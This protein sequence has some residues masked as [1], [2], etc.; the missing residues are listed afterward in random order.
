M[1]DVSPL[2]LFIAVQLGMAGVGW[3]VAGV[4]LRLSRRAALH[5]AAFNLLGL[6]AAAP[7]MLNPGP[8]EAL[9][10]GL[11][12]L[13]MTG[14]F[15]AMTRGIG[16]FLGRTGAAWPDIAAMAV[17]VLVTAWDV[18]F[19]SQPMLR[20]MLMSALLAAVLLRGALVHARP[21]RAEFGA[22]VAA[23]ITG[24]LLAVGAVFAWHVA[25]AA[26]ALVPEA[27]L[28]MSAPTKENVAVLLLLTSL[29]MLFNLTLCGMAVARLIR[30]LHHL[31]RH[32]GLTKLMNRRALMATLEAEQGRVR[33]GGPP[34]AL[35][36]V[37]VDHFKRVNDM[38]GHAVGDEVLCR[39]AAVLRRSAREVDTVAR[40]GGEEF[41]VLAPLT[42][43][44]GAAL[45]AERLRQ[46]V[47]N[48]TDEGQGA[49]PVT[50][51]IGVAL[52][53]PAPAGAAAPV[54]TAEAAL[55]RADVALYRAKDAG[56]NR[57]ELAGEHAAPVARAPLD[58]T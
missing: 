22:G 18:A 24:P 25:R 35:L 34:W 42:D 26:L 30:R 28:P 51:S 19:G 21:L 48:S 57:V 20:S 15:V 1:Q 32:D 52:S 9:L 23:L 4:R 11:S 56:R 2:L 43:L 54:E 3:W 50:V 5:W 45:L 49:V 44:H 29:V 6:L 13:A 39:V 31:S 17:A 27:Q 33:R 55:A 12:N 10:I 7:G 41:C 37:D 16:V 14:A 46:A 53:L 38:H 8:R 58:L 47:A 36:L 40:M